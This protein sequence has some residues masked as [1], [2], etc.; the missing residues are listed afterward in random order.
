M[1]NL[2]ISKDYQKHREAKK[3]I[4]LAGYKAVKEDVSKHY[5]DEL[6]KLS[7]GLGEY[8]KQ[9]FPF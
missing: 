5:R 7:V 2:S 6:H 3:K 4:M 9:T 1:F 8:F